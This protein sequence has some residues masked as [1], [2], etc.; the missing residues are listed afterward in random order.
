MAF[1]YANTLAQWLVHLADNNLRRALRAT[2]GSLVDRNSSFMLETATLAIKAG[3]STLA[4]TTEACYAL[5][6]GAHVLIA[7]NTD[8]P[9]L[10]G[11]SITAASYNVACFFI[12][13]AGT[14]SA[15]FGREAT[16][17]AGVEFPTFPEKNAL[18][19]YLLIT[20]SS[21]FTGGDTALDA[22]T[23]KYFSPVA[24]FDPNARLG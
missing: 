18:I 7:D 13:R 20:H 5:A 24:P 9:A 3:G 8:M 10:T 12:D 22:A 16:T 11:L 15:K 2:L 19:G 4:K 21:T 6:D 23:T 17:I 1:T 14:A